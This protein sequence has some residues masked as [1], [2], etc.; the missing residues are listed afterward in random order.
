MRIMPIM[1]NKML[2]SFGQP[3]FFGFGLGFILHNI[4]YVN[5]IIYQTKLE[6]ELPL[7][8]R[9]RYNYSYKYHERL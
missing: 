7:I 1:L 2:D 3:F 5:K 4:K 9:D 8:F 6:L